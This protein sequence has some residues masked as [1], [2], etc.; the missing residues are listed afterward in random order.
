VFFHDFADSQRVPFYARC[1]GPEKQPKKQLERQLKKT[2][3]KATGKAAKKTAEKVNYY[4]AKCYRALQRTQGKKPRERF[5]G[6]PLDTLKI[7]KS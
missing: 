4:G 1:L 3:E 5:S 6:M 2:A 7:R